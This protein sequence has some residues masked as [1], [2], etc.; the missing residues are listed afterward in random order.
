MK[1]GLFGG[2][3]ARG[4]P[5]AR[6][7]TLPP[8]SQAILIDRPV[9]TQVSGPTDPNYGQD[10]IL[11]NFSLL[12]FQ[13]Q[14]NQDFTISGLGVPVGPNETAIGDFTA[15]VESRARSA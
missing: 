1:F 14:A 13:V 7:S 4:G 11:N 6:S 2:A 9:P 3:R 15:L 5:V 12:G 10:L 8:G